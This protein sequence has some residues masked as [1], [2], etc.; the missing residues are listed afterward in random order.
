MPIPFTCPYC[1]LYTS[2]ADEYAGRE[3]PCSGCGASV[4]IP[5]N[6]PF[7]PYQSPQTTWIPDGGSGELQG[8]WSWILFAFD[9][10]IPRRIWWIVSILKNA[11]IYGLF[12]ALLALSEMGV[13]DEFG[14]DGFLVAFVILALI[15]AIPV[16][17]ITLA[18]TCKR[19][20][21]RDKSGWWYLITVVPYIGPLWL[22]IECGC[23]R[24]T[25]GPNA[26]GPDPT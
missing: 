14:S 26:Y 18:V 17:W 11:G 23:L 5:G 3:G 4:T 25:F 15:A 10:R 13:L 12:I 2:V 8:G 1:G 9:G 22:F 20:H 6:N 24:G 16:M 21:D 7:N 19:F